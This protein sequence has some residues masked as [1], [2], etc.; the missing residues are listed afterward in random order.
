MTV[1]SVP[2]SGQWI[3][4]ML[5]TNLGS[6]LMIS[7]DPQP[8]W[9]NDENNLLDFHHF[10]HSTSQHRKVSIGSA[11]KSKFQHLSL[12]QIGRSSQIPVH[13]HQFNWYF[14]ANFAEQFLDLHQNPFMLLGLSRMVLLG[15]SNIQQNHFDWLQHK[16]TKLKVQ[17]GKNVRQ[18]RFNLN[19]ETTNWWQKQ[20]IYASADFIYFM[21]V[22]TQRKAKMVGKRGASS[23]E[24]NC[25]NWP[26]TR[27][28]NLSFLS[29]SS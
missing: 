10:P 5:L 13:F 19:W 4:W 2:N 28:S 9:E 7:L 29:S 3:P 22:S 8:Y 20:W 1:D 21:R 26:N 18:E 15:R 14:I 16:W 12:V 6:R 11:T 27:E 23:R 25:F 17:T 24:D